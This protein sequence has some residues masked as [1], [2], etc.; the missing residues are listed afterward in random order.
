MDENIDLFVRYVTELVHQ[1]PIKS[2]L[3][4]FVSALAWI[5][6]GL[7][8]LIAYVVAI[9]AFDWFL[10][11]SKAYHLGVINSRK[12]KQGLFKILLYMG[13]I[14]VAVMLDRTL[15]PSLDIVGIDFELNF[16]MFTIFYLVVNESL[17]CLDHI[18]FFAAL[19][20]HKGVV[21]RKL[22]NKL[23]YWRSQLDD[24]SIVIEKKTTKETTTVKKCPPDESNE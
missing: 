22:L 5:L 10:G 17:S 7:D 9:M 15:R 11:M 1:F 24:S 16:R 14:F 13:V 8:Q 18:S 20:G 2:I 12:M 3:T 4:A 23:R 19:R 21:P 6:G